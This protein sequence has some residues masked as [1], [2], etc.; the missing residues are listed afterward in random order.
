MLMG[1]V[2]V[3]DFKPVNGRAYADEISFGAVK[4]TG[5]DVSAARAVGTITD[6][7][8]TAATP[9]TRILPDLLF[10][11]LSICVFE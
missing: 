6:N 5:L 3:A 9:A 8:R 7:P 1:V 2:K 11:F 4:L 10:I